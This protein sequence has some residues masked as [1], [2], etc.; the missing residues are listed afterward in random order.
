[1]LEDFLKKLGLTSVEIENLTAEKKPEGF[2]IDQLVIDVEKNIGENYVKENGYHSKEKFETASIQGMKA[3]KRE[4]AKVLGLSISGNEV[5]KMSAEEWQKALAEHKSKLQAASGA[6]NDEV[7][8]KLQVELSKAQ[9]ANREL[10]DEL[11]RKT[12]E[13]EKN[14]QQYEG[15][16]NS[17]L[18]DMN[19]R[20]RISNHRSTFQWGVNKELQ[21]ALISATIHKIKENGW[22]VKD[23]G[24][25]F[26]KQTGARVAINKVPIRTLE[27]LLDNEWKPASKQNNADPGKGGVT[28][29]G[30]EVKDEMKGTQALLQRIEASKQ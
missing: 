16:Y 19:I 17:K 2:D 5:E 3:I 12:E 10:T 15:E 1:M 7:I 26:D 6:T 27:E 18:S 21:D 14:K 28:Y 11:D 9:D 8:K 30:I 22:D 24:T 25:L 4:T 20:T 13:N 23:D 29:S